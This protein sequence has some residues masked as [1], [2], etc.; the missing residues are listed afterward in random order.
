M[1]DPFSS[2]VLLAPINSSAAMRDALN[3]RARLQRMLDFE[4]ALARAQAAVGIVPALVLDRIASAARAEG[5]DLAALAKAATACGNIA[6]PVIEALTAEVAK[7][8][9][10]AA[11]YVHCGAAVQD[12]IDTALVLDLRAALDALMIDLNRAIEG[13][14]ALAGRHRRTATI[15]R[16]MMQHA[17][18][19]P[20]GLALAGYAAALARSRERLRRLRREAL[21]L[22]FGG[23][24]GTLA[25][26]SDKGLD[27]AERLAAL[28]DLSLPEAP[29]HGNRDRLAEVAAALAILAGTCGKIGSDVSRLMQ[30]EAG[31]AFE[32]APM[33]GGAT[34]NVP[35]KR[36][37]TA[38]GAALAAATIAPNLLTAILVAQVQEDERSL[39]SWQAEW[40]TFPA[41]ALITSGG[42]HA[43]AD[44]SQGLEVDKE[45]M[46]ASLEA[47]HGV[48]MAEAVSGA[49][50]ARIGRA[51]AEGIVQA[52]G[53]EAA[54]T[55]RDLQDLLL[56]H[57]QVKR[58]LSVGELAKLFEPLS[59]QGVAQTFIDRIVGVL[60]ARPGKR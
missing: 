54:A 37:S 7:A 34:T 55:K 21:V 44:I 43:I 60:Q 38:A 5:Y 10:M 53:R 17:V 31:E 1:T 16:S 29:W 8:D 46:R 52:A 48:V 11:R 14:T 40:T 15:A 59:Y 26:L 9:P 4:A 3:D 24:A 30:T 2:S 45:R 39:G 42:L 28:L 58:S 41:L 19:M 57:D 23:T 49:L 20:F 25:A 6:Q 56:E 33:N 27:V 13:F 51:E 36:N 35:H 12:L 47:T 50:A 18:P 32:T 22:Q